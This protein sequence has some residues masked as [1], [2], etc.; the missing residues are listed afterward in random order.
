MEPA[1]AT[2]EA[3]QQRGGGRAGEQPEPDP[4]RAEARRQVQQGGGGQPD[5]PV[6]DEG[7][8]EAALGVVQA[9]QQPDGS[10]R[11]GRTR[12]PSWTRVACAGH[13]VGLTG[14]DTTG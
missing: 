3:A 13:G 9:A 8:A 2:V 1:D 7:D 5:G 14:R 6:A 11:T 12:S 4:E 10:S